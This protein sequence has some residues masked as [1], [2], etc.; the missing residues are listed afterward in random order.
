MLQNVDAADMQNN[1]QNS[2]VL[3]H[4]RSLTNE[5]QPDENEID[6]EGLDF[7]SPKGKKA[8]QS[9][10]MKKKLQRRK[11]VKFDKS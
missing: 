3:A 6:G 2:E 4:F 5:D 8:E 10:G 11:T 9:K 7:N 1:R